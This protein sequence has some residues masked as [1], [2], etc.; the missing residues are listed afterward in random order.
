MT[1]RRLV[2]PLILVAALACS[3]RSYDLQIRMRSAEDRKPLLRGWSGF[4]QGFSPAPFGFCWIEGTSAK[5]GVGRPPRSGTAQLRIRAWPFVHDGLPP[6]EM[7]LWV[8]SAFVDEQPMKEGPAEYSW[9]FPALLFQQ[10]ANDLYLVFSRASR[11]SDLSPR[12]SDGRFLAAAVQ[13]LDLTIE[14]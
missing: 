4:E 13:R 10:G 7:Q 2:A 5:I 1:V 14:P 12:A 8:N 11:P 3:P 9:S 6:Q